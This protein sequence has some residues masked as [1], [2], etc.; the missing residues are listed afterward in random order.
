MN[1]SSLCRIRK[2]IVLDISD[3]N[4]SRY[5]AVHGRRGL[6]DVLCISV[7]IYV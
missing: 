2:A 7:Q 4:E 3:S 6:V 5:E 1:N